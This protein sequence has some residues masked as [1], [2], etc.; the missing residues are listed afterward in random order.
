MKRL[1]YFFVVFLQ[2]LKTTLFYSWKFKKC[3]RKVVFGWLNKISGYS[4]IEIGD[5]C[6]FG[7]NLR[8]QAITKYRDELFAPQI[9]I[10]NNVVINQNFH[11]TCAEYVSIGNGT[12]ITANCGIF[13]IV[14]PY[15]DID[16]NP[17]LAK[18]KPKPVIIGTDCLI[19]MN[20]VILPGSRIGNHCVVGANSVVSGI[21]PDYCVIVGSPAKII[22]RYDFEEKQW[23]RIK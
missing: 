6:Y 18:I 21:F 19:G 9:V 12:S 8:L 5:Y 23:I 14:H 16:I 10:G 22:K 3:G 20:S 13:D 11:C 17:R 4:N 15:E 7:N 1:Y 2:I